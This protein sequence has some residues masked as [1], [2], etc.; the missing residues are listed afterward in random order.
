MQLL[1]R[2]LQKL[3]TRNIAMLFVKV[4]KKTN[5]GY[6]YP[7]TST[8]YPFSLC[9]QKKSNVFSNYNY[10][11]NLAT[12]VYGGFRVHHAVFHIPK[13]IANE[14]SLFARGIPIKNDPDARS[15]V[16]KTNNKAA[17]Q[18]FYKVYYTATYLLIKN[19]LVFLVGQCLSSC[20]SERN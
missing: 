11:F 13:S 17:L 5:V 6:Q 3:S 1:F 20:D 2:Q 4:E 15:A 10:R 14:I 18:F 8:R 9:C 12:L 19:F 16:C 7:W